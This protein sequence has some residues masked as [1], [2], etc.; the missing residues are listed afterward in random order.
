MEPGGPGC[1]HQ[2]YL[3]GGNVKIS[4]ERYEHAGGKYLLRYESAAGGGGNLELDVNYM[5]RV[6]L[7]PLVEMNSHTLGPHQVLNTFLIDIHELAAGKLA[8]LL[9]RHQARDLFDSNQLL[10]LGQLD[11]GRLRLAFIVYGAGNRRDWRTVSLDD[12]EF[13][14]REI[15]SQLIPT[16]NRR[17]VKGLEDI[18]EFGRRL[19]AECKESLSVVLPFTNDEMEFFNLLLDDGVI[20]PRLLTTDSEMQYK[21]NNQPMLQWKAINVIRHQEQD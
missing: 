11:P 4:N 5:Y 1:C 7:W 13:G 2:P 17:V 12:V 8:A 6:P 19:V 18:R 20:E 15:A 21:I 3:G 16:L 14:E 10:Q 9:S